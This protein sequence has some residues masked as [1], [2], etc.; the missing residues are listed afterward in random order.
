[1][2]SKLKVWIGNLDGSRQGLVIASSQIAGAKAV[3]TGLTDFRRYWKAINEAS[4]G[5]LTRFQ[6]ETLYTRPMA[7]KAHDGL[8]P[9]NKGRCTLGSPSK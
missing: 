8:V 6:V 7:S 1:M 9:W 3:N 2:P 5:E 4:E